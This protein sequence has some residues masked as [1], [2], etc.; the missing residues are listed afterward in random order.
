MRRFVVIDEHKVYLRGMLA[1]KYRTK[2]DLEEAKLKE[3][4]RWNSKNPRLAQAIRER[5]LL[6]WLNEGGA[7]WRV[8]RI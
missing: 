3:A 2:E 7:I 8:E 5:P 4:S 1:N 6:Q